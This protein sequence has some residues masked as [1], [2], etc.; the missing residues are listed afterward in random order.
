MTEMTTTAMDFVALLLE[1]GTDAVAV[2]ESAAAG[3]WL[4][5]SDVAY[6]ETGDGRKFLV[7][8]QEVA[9]R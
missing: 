7:T 8:V 9:A 4:V 1:D 2:V 6:V 5:T 3:G